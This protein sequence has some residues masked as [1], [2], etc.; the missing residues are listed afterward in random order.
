MLSTDSRQYRFAYEI[1]SKSDVPSDFPTLPSEDGW[2]A[3]LF[4]PGDTDS[5]WQPPEYSPQIY[6]LKGDRLLIYSHPVSREG[7]FETPL[8]SLMAVELQKSLLYGVIQFHMAS[9][10]GRFRYSTVHQRLFNRFLQSLRLQWLI[11]TELEVPVPAIQ[12]A[13]QY[14]SARCLRELTEE[15][16]P[17]ECLHEQYCQAAIQV[18]ERSWFFRR[19]RTTPAL[20]IAV[21]NRRVIAISTGAGERNDQYEMV[22]RYSSVCG[23]SSMDIMSGG[24]DFVI[25]HI[26]LKNNAVWKFLIP[27]AHSSSILRLLEAVRNL[28]SSLRDD[29]P[30]A[31]IPK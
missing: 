9:T 14:S 2:L 31:P 12:K 3:A 13:M 15:L 24:S 18:K 6:L 29:E 16:D 4:M 25:L 11:S 21:T 1:H 7:L 5:F 26:R 28:L 23:L 20:L 27:D 17:N 30:N 8:S 10:T 22:I 19:S